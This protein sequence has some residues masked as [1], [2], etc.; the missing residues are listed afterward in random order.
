MA[1][2]RIL[3]SIAPIAA[4]AMAGPGGW[5]ALAAGAATGAGIAALNNEDILTGAVSGGM[6]G[7]GGA[8]IRE[9]MSGTAASLSGQGVTGMEGPVNLGRPTIGQGFKASIDKP[10]QFLSN[11]GDGSMGRGAAKLGAVGLPAL[12]QAMVPEYNANP[13]DNPMS[14]YDPNRKLNLN[15]TTGIQNA[16]TRDS[17]LRLN[18]PFAQ[19]AD[20]GYLSPEDTEAYRQYMQQRQLEGSMYGQKEAPVYDTG[21][22]QLENER[23]ARMR[24]PQAV[25][26]LRA[27]VMRRTDPYV[28]TERQSRD[29]FNSLM[30]AFE[31]ERLEIKAMP[32]GPEKEEI[33][34]GN[35]N[36]SRDEFY[37]DQGGYL[38]TGFRGLRSDGDYVT[39]NT[40]TKQ[41][42]ENRRAKIARDM[43]EQN[44]RLAK[45]EL[46]RIHSKGDIAEPRELPEYSNKY[47]DSFQ[48]DVEKYYDP[49]DFSGDMDMRIR[50]EGLDSL[51]PNRHEELYEAYRKE[52]SNPYPKEVLMQEGGYLETGMGDGMSDDI[53]TSID[54]EQP[55][56]LSENEFVVPADVVSHIGNGSSDAGAEQLYAMM[57]R[58]RHART[59]NEEQGREINAQ[60][61][62]PA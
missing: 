60:E 22:Q 16:L 47:Y 23:A 33:M 51:F 36:F 30:D 31:Q 25:E 18:Q 43:F 1:F 12:G 26:N 49:R 5:A 40:E 53:S 29:R 55:A 27:Q 21:L 3:G 44:E 50:M 8:G 11:F 46:A 28:G 24:D 42:Q 59:G 4:G 37:Y 56:R 34:R 14:K 10:G 39:S 7:Y 13:D 15:M 41:Q 20:G 57:D 62:M 58:I 38:E 61:Y 52:R 32:E 2:G 35:D 45:E 19:F 17:G 54:G 6:G 48:P 9:A